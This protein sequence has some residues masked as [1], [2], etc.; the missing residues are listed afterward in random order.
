MYKHQFYQIVESNRIEKSIHQ[1]ESNR[2]K[3][4]YFSANRNAL[5]RSVRWPLHK[6]LRHFGTSAEVSQRHF[7]A[8]DTKKVK[9]FGTKDIVPNCLMSEV[10]WVRSVH[11]P[12]Y[13]TSHTLDG[14]TKG[15]LISTDGPVTF[16]G[17]H[18]DGPVASSKT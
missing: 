16:F 18:L 2:I 11:T 13:M 9:H 17:F 4:N 15:I 6:M 3:S 10:S 8:N 7:S 12:G 5:C 14:Y 1:H